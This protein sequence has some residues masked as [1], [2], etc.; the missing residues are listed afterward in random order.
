MKKILLSGV[1]ILIVSLAVGCTNGKK[2]ETIESSE[3]SETKVVNLDSVNDLIVQRKYDEAL[4][5]LEKINIKDNKN[6]EVKDL[7]NQIT[8][9]KNA[10][11][12]G[13][14]KEYEEAIKNF[15]IIIDDKNSF[16]SL[17]NDS[18]KEIEEINK[19]I[20]D[21]K[22]KIESVETFSNYVNERNTL[23]N[24]TGKPDIIDTIPDSI[25]KKLYEDQYNKGIMDLSEKEL[26]IEI[27]KIYPSAEIK[28][29]SQ[30]GPGTGIS[31]E[32]EAIEMAKSLIEDS[33][34]AEYELTASDEGDYFMIFG[35]MIDSSNQSMATNLYFY[36]YKDGRVVKVDRNGNPI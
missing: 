10:K 9:F 22:N 4:V 27:A 7:I 24:N 21:E 26:L 32:S 33:K 30:V 5:E 18:K 28:T 35:Q 14:E 6:K 8:L 16:E 13:S 11:T 17:K 23:K 25:F 12:L 2:K 34:R 19:L 31:N 36:V 1:L 29:D 3:Q 15:Q 20:K